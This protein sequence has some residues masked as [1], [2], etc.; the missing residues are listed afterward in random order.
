MIKFKEEFEKGNYYLLAKDTRTPINI[1]KKIQFIA[2]GNKYLYDKVT[3]TIEKKEKYT[4][5]RKELK[6]LIKNYKYLLQQK[7]PNFNHMD[8]LI[9]RIWNLNIVRTAFKYKVI[10]PKFSNVENFLSYSQSYYYELQF[11]D[12]IITG[13]I[14]V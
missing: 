3:A 10:I 11:I 1:L 2:I 13:K 7:E 4:Q 12:D 8:C 5:E 6:N 9:E 14:K